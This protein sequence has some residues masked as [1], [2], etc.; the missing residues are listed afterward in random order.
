[1]VGYL[2]EMEE[3]GPAE[4]DIVT[5]SEGREREGGRNLRRREKRVREGGVGEPGLIRGRGR[6][7]GESCESE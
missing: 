1:M 5:R 7:A 3:E 2:E 4:A 6:A